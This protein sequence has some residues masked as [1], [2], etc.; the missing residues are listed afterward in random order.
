LLHRPYP[1]HSPIVNVTGADALTPAQVAP[2]TPANTITSDPPPLTDPAEDSIIGGFPQ[3]SRRTSRLAQREDGVGQ[4]QAG[5]PNPEAMAVSWHG[6]YRSSPAV[7]VAKLDGAD[8]P[9]A[10]KQRC[11]FQVY[12]YIARRQ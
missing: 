6:C 5:W 2:F 10:G 8:R 4:A 9:T 1:L 12:T 11:V 3:T 7:P